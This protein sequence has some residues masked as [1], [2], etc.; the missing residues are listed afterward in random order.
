[1]LASYKYVDFDGQQKTGDCEIVE[2]L[3]GF[4]VN[5]ITGPQGC[6][7]VMDPAIYWKPVRAAILGLLGGRDLVSYEVLA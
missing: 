7:K 1:M 6:S 2:S 3:S 5:G 4:C